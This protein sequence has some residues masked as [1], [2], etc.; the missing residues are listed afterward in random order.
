MDEFSAAP[1]AAVATPGSVEELLAQVKLLLSETLVRQV[2]ACFQF[3]VSSEDG[4]CHTYYVDLSQ[5]K[6]WH[7]AL[8]MPRL[9]EHFNSYISNK[10]MQI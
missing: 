2:G 5:G 4:Q 10:Q 1:Q 7:F 9:Q 6:G 3:D 8:N